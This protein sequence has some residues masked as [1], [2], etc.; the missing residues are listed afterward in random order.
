M[1]GTH[2]LKPLVINK[3]WKPHAF[4][5]KRVNINQLPVE[6]HANKKAWMT[7][8]IFMT[9]LYK[10]DRMFGRQK[11]KIALVIDN[12]PSHPKVKLENIKLVFLPPNT[13]SRTQP[14]DQGIIQNFKCHYRAHYVKHGL[15]KAMERGQ[16][17][18]W[19]VLDA[20]YGIQAAWNKVTP[21]TITNCFRHCGFESPQVPTIEDEEDPE[22][23]IPLAQLAEQLRKAGLPVT[24]EEMEAYSRVDDKLLTS[25][26][27]T[28]D[29]IAKE[30]IASN[31]EDE[32]EDEEEE[33]PSAT[34]VSEPPTLAQVLD[35][36]QVMKDALVT[37]PDDTSGMWEHLSALE[38]IFGEVFTKKQKQTTMLGYFTPRMPRESTTPP[39][40]TDTEPSPA[41]FDTRL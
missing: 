23:D 26:P 31:Q 25:C 27:M 37:Q 38:K 2:K 29:D 36:A 28:V 14:M 17:P 22:D 15:L 21:A 40:L 7:S 9:W 6:Y 1:T 24:D 10:L 35:A 5:Q 30:V 32:E 41:S 12:C 18:N 13:T 8:D 19:N 39:S 4:T 3:A 11:R 33:V 34:P 20:I 16:K